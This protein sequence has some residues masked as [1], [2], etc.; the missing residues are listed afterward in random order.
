MFH[1]TSIL[2]KKSKTH[3]N[4]TSSKQAPQQELGGQILPQHAVEASHP[5]IKTKEYGRFYDNMF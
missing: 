2:A 5:F 3:L 4:G 1:N